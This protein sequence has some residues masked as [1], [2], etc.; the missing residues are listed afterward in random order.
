MSI[1]TLSIV[2]SRSGAEQKYVQLL[3]A[4]P[5]DPRS[6]KMMENL[7]S[8]FFYCEQQIEEIGNVLDR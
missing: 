5:L 7:R 8:Q 6:V 1:L 3:R 2:L 4:R